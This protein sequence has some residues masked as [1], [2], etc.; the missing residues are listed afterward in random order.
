MSF[1][2]VNAHSI[3]KAHALSTL[4]ADAISANADVIC[5]TETWLKVK[6][7]QSAF[8]L[9]GYACFRLDRKRRRG[10][11]V[12][13]YIKHNLAPVQC[14]NTATGLSISDNHE[15]LWVRMKSRGELH[16]LVCVCYHPPNPIYNTKDFIE[17]KSQL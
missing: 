4:A 2:V 8:D 7:A 14:L 5:L 11:G 10:G 3:A 12:A 6:H 9:E 15:F 16:Y 13:V 1:I 17:T